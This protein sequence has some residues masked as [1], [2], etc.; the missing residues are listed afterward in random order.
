[1]GIKKVTIAGGGVLGSQIAYQS[2]FRGFDVTIWLRSEASI[3]RCEPKLDRLQGIYVASLEAA[4]TDKSKWAPGFGKLEEATDE[5]IDELKAAAVA[6]RTNLHLTTDWDEAFSDADLVIEAVAE[7]PQQKIAFYEKLQKHLP[8]KTTSLLILRRCYPALLP[9]RRGVPKSFWDTTLPI[10]VG[11]AILLR[12][13]R[14]LVP[15]MMS[16]SSWYSTP[17]TSLW[18]PSSC[19]RS[20]RVMCSIPCSYPS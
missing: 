9:K 10:I 1:M 6:A 3:G 12:L 17:K 14:I 4:K 2:A 8:E 11:L 18:F 7:D 19:T 16:T 5:H 13:C 15:A 20:S